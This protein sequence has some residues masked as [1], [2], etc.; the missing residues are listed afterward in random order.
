MKVISVFKTHVDV[1]FTDLPHKVLASYADKMLGDVVATCEATSSALPH[2][3]F[4]WTMPA[5]VLLYCLEYSTEELRRRTEALIQNGQIVW[6]A[7]PFTIRSEFFS[8]F[9]LE[10]ATDYA[11]ILSER[12]SKPM[13]KTAKM[14]D[15]PG[16]TQALVDALYDS[17]VEFL[18]LGCNPASIYPDVP[19]L[20][21]WESKSGKSI[22]VYYDKT[23]GSSLTPPDNWK[24]SV[25]LAMTITNDN[26][27]VQSPEITMQQASALGDGYEYTT[28]SL[29]DFW[30]ELKSC[31]LSDLPVVKGEL[32]DTWIH[33]LGAFPES[34]EAI[35]PVKKD[36]ERI[37]KFLQAK[38]DT[39]F[40]ALTQR[41]FDNLYLFGEHSGGVSSQYHIG[42][43]RE[44]DKA[45][46]LEA[47][48]GPELTYSND[49]WN[50]ERAWAF[51]ARDAALELKA[52]V[53]EKYGE[54]DCLSGDEQDDGKAPT[55][56]IKEEDGVLTFSHQSGKEVKFTYAY[57]L[58]GYDTIESYMDSYLRDK[59]FWAYCDFGRYYRDPNKP[60]SAINSYPKIDDKEYTAVLTAIEEK[61]GVV[62]ATYDTIAES[63]AMYGNLRKLTVTAKAVGDAVHVTVEAKE[64]E[65]TMYAEGGN[66]SFTLNEP[67]ET[68]RIN[69]SGIEIDPQKDIVKGAN[70]RLFAI[71]RYAIV[72]GLRFE[73]IHTPLLSFGGNAIYE[74][75]LAPFTMPQTPSVVFNL[76]N[77][78]WGTGAPQWITGSYKYEFVIR[79]A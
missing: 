38:G 10:H 21:R 76:F 27:G 22:V 17:G 26:C 4:V 77:N 24:Y 14:T 79:A 5:F 15:L 59:P 37:Y 70:T 63:Y 57:N 61:D 32:G 33:A 58:I 23:Y 19:L 34:C 62:T 71:D 3:R 49:G 66:I 41:Y 51:A 31:D 69:K 11:R 16:H 35:Y 2:L 55:W 28:G 52:R 30:E 6:H 54:I 60:N 36:F 44:Y 75:N 47:L 68:I 72:N 73:T 78:M 20:F 39:E 40:D 12:Y 42:A 8:H 48:K 7:L 18:H 56:Q 45:K 67:L 53:R 74:P 50:D 46:L 29:D 65:P 64:K 1:G 43:H 9:E 13:P 25:H